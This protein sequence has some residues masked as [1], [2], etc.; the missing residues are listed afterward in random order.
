MINVIV[1]LWPGGD[2][3]RKRVL[4]TAMI[5]NV[6]GTA[7]VGN[8]D[9]EIRGGNRV[10]RA[11]ALMERSSLEGHPRERNVW[12]LVRAVL[13]TFAPPSERER[14]AEEA[15]E[16]VRAEPELPGEPP[17]ELLALLAIDPVSVIRS[18]VKATKIA[19]EKS[20]RKRFGAE[21]KG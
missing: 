13:E 10:E 6:G 18:G 1:E 14:F 12:C 2:E 5:A 15:I 16:V 17:V 11:N 20:L 7:E 9:Y 8:Y 21:S 19:I 4:A 3:A